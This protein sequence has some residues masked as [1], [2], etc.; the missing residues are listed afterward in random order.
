[1]GRKS[2]LFLLIISILIPFTIADA[3]ING[4]TRVVNLT[5]TGNIT[6]TAGLLANGLSLTSRSLSTL[7]SSQG[8]VSIQVT[9]DINVPA[10]A[11]RAFN[12]NDWSN[13]GAYGPSQVYLVS[14]GITVVTQATNT[15]AKVTVKVMVASGVNSFTLTPGPCAEVTIPAI[16]GAVGVATIPINGILTTIEDSQP[17]YFTVEVR[18]TAAITIK[19]TVP[20]N[21]TGNIPGPF[22]ANYLNDPVP[23][24]TIINLIRIK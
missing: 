4:T 9:S 3:N 16:S 12:G 13:F 24:A 23:P 10:N 22:S 18:S 8:Y 20:D 5:A 17:R 19:A 21:A 15:L 14:G 2:I 1:M 6:A 7:P 11:W